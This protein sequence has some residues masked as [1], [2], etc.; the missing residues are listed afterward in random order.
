M[1]EAIFVGT[2]RGLEARLVPEAGFSLELIRADC[3]PGGTTENA[4]TH[5][6]FTHFEPGTAPLA[7]NHQGQFP[8][9]TASFNLAPGISL[10]DAVN[11]ISARRSYQMRLPVRA[12]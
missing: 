6:A 2:E 1:N 4:R 5:A 11:A 9:V 3:V 10:G 8:V 12:S 7:V